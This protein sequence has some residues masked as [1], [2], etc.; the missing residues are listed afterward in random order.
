MCWVLNVSLLNE[1]KK[2]RKQNQNQIQILNERLI[3][4]IFRV[5]EQN[6]SDLLQDCIH[7]LIFQMNQTQTSHSGGGHLMEVTWWRSPEGNHLV[8]VT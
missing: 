1:L 2:T 4:F 6:S 7:V 5:P 8:E 3:P